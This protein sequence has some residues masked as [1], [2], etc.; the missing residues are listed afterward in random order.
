MKKLL[1]V[2]MFGMVFGQ[3][4]LTTKEYT[5]PL[6]LLNFSFNEFGRYIYTFNIDD[7]QSLIDIYQI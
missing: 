1:C 4:E 5:I 7:I 6:S 2:L 3:A